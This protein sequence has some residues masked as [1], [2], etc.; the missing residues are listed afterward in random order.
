MKK[1]SISVAKEKSEKGRKSTQADTRSSSVH[2]AITA[3]S[4]G[5]T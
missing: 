3:L 2:G 4:D 5:A 1:Q